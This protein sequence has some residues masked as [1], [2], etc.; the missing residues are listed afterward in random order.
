MTDNVGKVQLRRKVEDFSLIADFLSVAHL[1]AH[2]SKPNLHFWYQT[3]LSPALSLPGLSDSISSSHS[4]PE[5][6]PS[7]VPEPKPF[8][9]CTSQPQVIVSHLSLPKSLKHNSSSV[10]TSKYLTACIFIVNKLFKFTTYPLSMLLRVGQEIKT[11][12]ETMDVFI[13]KSGKSSY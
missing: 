11:K 1:L 13:H 5:Y 6:I 7:A 9:H 3:H 8:L 2:S 12:H 10:Q 4:P